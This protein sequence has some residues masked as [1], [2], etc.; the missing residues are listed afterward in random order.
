MLLA[1]HSDAPIIGASGGIS[2]I[3]AAVILLMKRNRM[4]FEGRFGLW[5]FIILWI[6]IAGVFGA[7]G[8]PDGGNV[9]WAAHIGGFFAGF[10]LL[11]PLM[12]L[13]KRAA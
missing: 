2:G 9:A 4:G 1:P 5:P 10:L 3:F 7:L 11:D 8:S 6:V 13:G 12:K